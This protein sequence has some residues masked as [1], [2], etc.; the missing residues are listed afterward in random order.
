MDLFS[1]WKQL[2]W[3]WDERIASEGSAGSWVEMRVFRGLAE[4]TTF[5]F[6]AKWVFQVEIWEVNV[7]L[8]SEQ[9]FKI[10]SFQQYSKVAML[11]CQAML[12]QQNH[13]YRQ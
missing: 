2:I 8:I 7:S 4:G 10:L 13:I 1:I 12:P 3:V 9:V 6:G 5:I 11:L